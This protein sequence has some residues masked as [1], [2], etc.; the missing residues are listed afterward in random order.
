M[1]M[2]D[3]GVDEFIYFEKIDDGERLGYEV[4]FVDWYGTTCK[5]LVSSMS[6]VA[7]YQN[8]SVRWVE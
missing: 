7:A 6:Q 5:K 8:L 4:L 2:I 1:N 3:N